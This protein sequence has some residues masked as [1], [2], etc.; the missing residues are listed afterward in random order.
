MQ[1]LDNCYITLI[2]PFYGSLPLFHARLFYIAVCFSPHFY[3]PYTSLMQPSYSFLIRHYVSMQPLHRPS[4]ALMQ[5]V[6]SHYTARYSFSQRF[7]CCI[8]GQRN[9]A[10][11]IAR[12]PCRAVVVFLL[13]LQPN[14]LGTRS[15]HP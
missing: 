15:I 4:A 3:R 8:A 14:R 6:C 12:A 7:S 2:P 9:A 11:L 10:V 13:G 5:A 1:P